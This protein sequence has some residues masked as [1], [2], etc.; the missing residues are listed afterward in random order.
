M[1]A[2]ER[3]NLVVLNYWRSIFKEE[4]CYWVLS[5][6][7]NHTVNLVTE[8]MELETPEN[9]AWSNVFGIRSDV[10]GYPHN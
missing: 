7:A 2:Q 8:N 4:K 6:F 3:N 1:H 9:Q 10:L 5:V